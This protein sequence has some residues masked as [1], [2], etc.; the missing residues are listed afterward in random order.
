MS[1]SIKGISVAWLTTI[2]W[3]VTPQ[4]SIGQGITTTDHVDP[5][6][7]AF[8]S[9]VSLHHVI[10]YEEMS[11][12]AEQKATS[13]HEY[14]RYSDEIYTQR[15]NKLSSPIAL[16]YNNEVRKY[17][18]MY[19]YHKRGLTARMMGLSELYFPL[20]EEALDKEGLP[21]ELKYLAM[22]ESALNPVAVSRVGAT[23][24]WQFMYNTG[25]M[26]QLKIDS[27]V[28]ERRDPEKATYAACRYFKDMYAIYNDWLLVIASYNCGPG[29]VNKAIRRAGGKTDFWEIARYLPAET[30]GYVP[31][32][33]AVTYVM[34]YSDEHSIFPVSP[35]YHYYQVDTI[36]ITQQI[37]L[38]KIADAIG[39]PPEVLSYLN[40]LYKRGII[41]S[42]E[43]PHILR[44]P[45]ASLASFL[46]VEKNLYDAAA[47][48]NPVALATATAHGKKVEPTGPWQYEN[49]EV[50][51][52][53]TVRKG[54][55][56]SVIASRL[57]CSVPQLKKWN[58]LASGTIQTGQ[59]LSYYA[60]VQVKVP[61][62][63]QETAE[64]QEHL[65]TTTPDVKEE[66]GPRQEIIYHI[67]EKGD[68]LWN[69]A[70][71][72]EGVTVEQLM[73][74]N[75]ISNSNGLVPGTRIKVRV[76]G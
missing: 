11:G 37:S 30:R 24:L 10:K 15:M 2:C 73:E 68:T 69:I 49:R 45:V 7:A 42:S 25:K 5:I 23:G 9:L 27:W 38:R 76:N 60:M 66:D 75:K 41:P 13:R 20:F 39:V 40:P 70:Q 44:L 16:T 47:P 53:Y 31:A 43:Q 46:S 72:Y 6:V 21:L 1:Y 14:P 67:V 18:E 58:R 51:K 3:L 4:S 64:T 22:V 65:T 62:P 19:A 52:V 17:L 59:R 36:G 12:P 56:L 32:F 33:I 34:N 71:R 63:V 28:D 29:N 54:D 61:I 8:D 74:I 48:V 57:K 55:N 35:A 50:R 26:Y